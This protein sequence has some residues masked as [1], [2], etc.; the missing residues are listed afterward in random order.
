MF[1]V[2][3]Q[4]KI[5]VNLGKIVNKRVFFGFFKI[6][7]DLVFLVLFMEDFS[8]EVGLEVF[9]NTLES[10]NEPKFTQFE[11]FRF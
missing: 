7:I 1:R 4:L 10:Q 3:K 8:E 5:W 11:R 6:F 9:G 2:R